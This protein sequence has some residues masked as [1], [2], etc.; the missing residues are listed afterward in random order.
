MQREVCRIFPLMIQKMSFGIKPSCS[1]LRSKLIL[2]MKQLFLC[3][4]LFTIF[5]QKVHSIFFLMANNYEVPSWAGKPPPGLH[6]DISKE[7]AGGSQKFI[8]KFMIDEK[9]V[10]VTTTLPAS[11]LNH[12]IVP[13]LSLRTQSRVK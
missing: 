12:S 8:Q 13:V 5:S 9:K 4:F 7:D 11:C 3:N 6:L 2:S 10:R 1:C